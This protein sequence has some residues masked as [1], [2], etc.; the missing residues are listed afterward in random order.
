MEQNR[1]ITSLSE[2]SCI[3]IRHRSF[4]DDDGYPVE[5]TRRQWDVL[6]FF[7][8][9]VGDPLS[10]KEIYQNA[11]HY[12]TM[13]DSPDVAQAVRD[14]VTKLRAKSPSLRKT[15][16]TVRGFGFQFVPPKI[17][18]IDQNCLSSSLT[19]DTAPFIDEDSV[20]H[21][22]KILRV[23]I[24]KL[25]TGKCA[26]N[27]TGMGGLGKTVIARVLYHKLTSQFSSIGW[28]KYSGDLRNSLLSAIPLFEDITDS[29]ERWSVLST[30]LK[31]DTSPKLMI[32][33][34]VD[35]DIRQ[36]QDPLSDYSLQEFSGWPGMTILITSRIPEI[37][38]Y[39]TCPLMPLEWDECEDLFYHYY[40]PRRQKV[41]VDSDREKDAARHLI[42][43]AGRH[44][45]AI[46]L[47]ARGAK[48][49]NSLGD[50]LMRIQGT[51]FSFPNLEFITA[52]SNVSVSAAAQLQHLFD[53]RTRSTRERQA[54]LDFSVLPAIE[55][56]FSEIQT[57]LGYSEN[58]LDRLIDEGWLQYDYGVQMH[59]LVKEAIV[60]GYAGTDEK[61]PA[62]TTRILVEEICSGRFI[63]GEDSFDSASRKWEIAK[64]IINSVNIPDQDTQAQI[65][66]L[67]GT[68]SFSK[69]R[70]TDAIHFLRQALALFEDYGENQ[71]ELIATCCNDIGYYLSYTTNGRDEAETFLRKALILRRC[72]KTK[73]ISKYS[74]NIATSCDYLGYLLSD[75]INCYQEAETLLREALAIRSSLA[76]S[77]Q[78]VSQADVAWT[79]DNLGF[80]LSHMKDSREEA[81]DLL[82][83]ALHM[84]LQ[85]AE[86]HPGRHID[87]VAW[88][89]NNLALL[90]YAEGDRMEEARMLY[91]EALAY[92]CRYEKTTPGSHLADTALCY[93]NLGVLTR[94]D[95]LQ[96]TYTEELFHRALHINRK[97]N[98]QFPGMYR[99]EVAVS[100]NNMA[101]IIMLDRSRL[102]EAEALYQEALQITEVLEEQHPGFFQ[103]NIADITFNLAVLSIM[104]GESTQESTKLLDEAI[105]I[106]TNIPGNKGKVKMAKKLQYTS[107][108]RQALSHVC[109]NYIQSGARTSSVYPGQVMWD[110]KSHG[111]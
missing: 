64:S 15:I 65:Y 66:F 102:K 29:G 61:A 46:E 31:H 105:S 74:I 6:S 94:S 39:A 67:L 8:E 18:K 89:Y 50:Y 108:D 42:E 83:T 70:P 87:E 25:T 58:D 9:R 4:T 19:R 11:W 62:G 78:G 79:M 32:I 54:L 10:H 21:R 38:G 24:N 59:P 47:L 75:Q 30:Y 90:L 68:S 101:T 96:A 35:A 82:R 106:W 51:G 37:Q 81:E 20:L 45:Y 69:Y 72:L 111:R 76:A 22:T 27:L 93:G 100:C 110:E 55:L 97:L 53:L 48:Y 3:D 52:H 17:E 34:N 28:V 92:L 7:V 56:S 104:S 77:N 16:L 80:L 109:I 2:N 91:L 41:S 99:A 57:W 13:M 107:G 73:D 63:S 12:E 60:L 71:E 36:D 86:K 98:E 5:L 26:V 103:T 33:D 43:L 14:V 40:N 95:L 85:L 23:L 49:A 84:R 44:T 88:T 1:Y